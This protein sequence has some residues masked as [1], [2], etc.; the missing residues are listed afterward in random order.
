L[1]TTSLPSWSWQPETPQTLSFTVVQDEHTDVILRDGRAE[2]FVKAVFRLACSSCAS[3]GQ[4]IVMDI[5]ANTGYYSMLAGAHGCSVLALDAQPGCAPWFESARLANVAAGHFGADRVRIITRP[6]DDAA[7]LVDVTADSCWVMHKTTKRARPKPPGE[8]RLR[9]EPIG[10]VEL[11]G[12]LPSGPIALAK[13]DCEGA[14]LGVL[15][16][17]APLL[18][19]IENLVVE[20]APGW[21][22]HF[23]NT[24]A[25][26]NRGGGGKMPRQRRPGQHWPAQS[27]ESGATQVALLL[28]RG[29]RSCLTSTGRQFTDAAALR[30]Y[31]L[32]FPSNGFWAQVDMWCARDAVVQTRARRLL[33]EREKVLHR[34]RFQ[35]L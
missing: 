6:V 7:A 27:R 19:R 9:L 21:W 23:E 3:A 13:V 17:L 4:H 16:S 30:R 8:G 35:G 34:H 14:E 22:S 2:G 33:D 29:Y 15:R 5:G 31:L 1:L 10:G 24:S 32:R 11:A 26:A 18:P 28:R 20:L 12:L 25:S